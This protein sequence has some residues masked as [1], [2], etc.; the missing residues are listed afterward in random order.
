MR[1]IAS[2][3]RRQDEPP[4]APRLPEGAGA[5]LHLRMPAFPSPPLPTPPPPPPLPLL[6]TVVSFFT[7]SS[8]L[9]PRPPLSVP[10]CFCLPVPARFMLV[11]S[12]LSPSS[13]CWFYSNSR[14]L[15]SVSRIPLACLVPLRPP[16]IFLSLTPLCSISPAAVAFA[17]SPA[18]AA[19]AHASVCV[20][21]LQLYELVAFLGWHFIAVPLKVSDSIDAMKHN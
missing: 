8:S 3:L 9:L 2:Q 14:P 4:T 1:L 21:L 11:S 19:H 20:A 6:H 12:F 7:S 18:C 10:S 15:Q 17:C 5:R 13:C 16:S